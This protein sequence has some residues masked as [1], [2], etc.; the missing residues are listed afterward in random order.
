MAK[1][2]RIGPAYCFWGDFQDSTGSFTDVTFLG[3]TRGD[4]VVRLNPQIARGRVDQFGPIPMAGAIW[5]GAMAP[6]V[7][8]PLVDEDYTK[9]S[10]VILG[11][12]VVTNGSRKAL[13]FPSK[14]QQYTN[15]EIGMLA[16]IPVRNTYANYG[17]GENP[18]G[19]P[20]AWYFSGVVPR[21]MGDFVY[22]EIAE[23]DDA[24][25]P[26]TVT[27]IGTRRENWADG[28]TAVVAGLEIGWR[29]SP[30]AAGLTE[31]DF[32]FAAEGITKFNALI[33]T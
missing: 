9:L 20:D 32:P 27:F 3:Q 5:L 2:Y 12:S 24:F 30:R 1:V 28:S 31:A 15:A 18:W 13:K 25:N 29:G 6:E 14:P 10:K 21:D 8:L 19:D 4:V 23:S 26:H 16:I 17:S 7:V 33:A 11:S 22:Q